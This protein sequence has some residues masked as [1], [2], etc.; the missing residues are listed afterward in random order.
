MEH[1]PG[2]AGAGFLKWSQM[3]PALGVEVE[4]PKI[5]KT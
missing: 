3:G 5:D 4:M 2:Q 1:L